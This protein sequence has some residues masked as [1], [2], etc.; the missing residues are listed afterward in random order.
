MADKV[1]TSYQLKLVAGFSDGDERTISYENPRAN[2]T[3]ADIK[4]LDSLAADVLIGD[5]YGAAFSTFKDAGIYEITK[6][7]LDINS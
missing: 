7:E 1:S 3:A 4:A 2:L 6:V 5:K